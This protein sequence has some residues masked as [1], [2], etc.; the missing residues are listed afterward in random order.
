MIEPLVSIIIP[1]YNSAST[2]D[3]CLRSIKSQTYKNIEIIIVD[4]FSKDNTKE[5]AE[6]CRVKIIEDNSIRSKARN[7]AEGASKGEFIF[8]IDSDME[9]SEKVVEECIQKSEE[10]DSIIVPEIS[11]GIGF[12]AKCKSIEK[13]CYIGDDTI[14]AARFFSKKTFE[15]V[16]GYDPSLELAEDWDIHQRIKNTGFKVGRIRSLIRHNEQNINLWKTMKKKYHYGKTVEKYRIKHPEKF[17]SQS[18]LIRP[19]FIK[20]W[21]LLTRDP[22]TS[23]G[24]LF[25]KFCEIGAIGLGYLSTKV[26]I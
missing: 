23:F 24:M 16:C 17:S 2:L 15:T 1:T 19:A 25:M 3:A 8:S 20:N 14:E 12:W 21:K 18:K 7:I 26:K 10:L 11:F 4:N 13:R 6:R 5:I 9:L 22:I